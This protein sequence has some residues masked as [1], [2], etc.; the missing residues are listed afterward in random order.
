MLANEYTAARNPTGW[1]LSEKLDGVRALWDGVQFITRNGNAIAAP[2]WFTASLPNVMLDGELWMGRGMFQKLAGIVRSSAGDWSRVRF[3]VFDAVEADGGFE[4][5]LSFASSALAGCPVASVVEHVTC[6]GREHLAAY[7]TELIANGAEGVMLRRPNSPY[8]EGRSDDLLKHKPAFDA[9]A[10]VVGYEA[11]KGKHAGRVGSL[12]VRF[13]G[14]T[15]ALGVGLTNAER[16]APPALGSLV[17]FAYSSL[18]DSGVPRFAKF[19]A[20]RDYE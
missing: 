20:V 11:G 9:E 8:V 10:E 19:V 18:T 17:I 4:S 13:A 1:M 15:F 5:R 3:M 7:S 2:A 14:V 6:G 16:T 12:V